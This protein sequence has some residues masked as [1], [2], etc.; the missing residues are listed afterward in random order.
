MKNEYCPTCGA[1]MKLVKVLDR[2][3]A[4]MKC[5]HCK[6]VLKY[7]YDEDTFPK[8]LKSFNW[9]AFLMPNIWGFGNGYPITSICL[10]L[11]WLN[12][13]FSPRGSFEY[14]T[15]ST[16]GYFIVDLF[17]TFY[18]GFKGNRLSWKRKDWDSVDDFESAQRKWAIA[19]V[20]F[21]AISFVIGF[22]IGFNQARML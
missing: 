6:K 17:F 22:I 21:V 18:W 9:G 3:T 16:I 10:I 1:E 8:N 20:I 4:T 15:I 11:L 13:I 2:R 7:S 19:G 12:F 5:D 14:F